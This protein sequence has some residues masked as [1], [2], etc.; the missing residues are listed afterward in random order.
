MDRFLLQDDNLGRL[1]QARATELYERLQKIDVAN[2]GMPAHCLDYFKKSHSQRLFFSIE[3]SAHLLY[4]SIK[5]SGR[6]PEEMIIMDYGAGVGTLYLLAKMTGFKQVVYNDHLDDWR[7][8][9]ELIAVAIGVHIDH[10]I[11]G[12][13]DDCL[14]RLE[15]FRFKCDI[16]TS[17]NVI[18]HIY[19]LDTFYKAI[20][21]K[22][23]QALIYSSTTA[24]KSNPAS[25]LKH[26]LWHRK[27][28]KVFKGKRLVVIERQAHGLSSTK[29]QNL[30][31][32]TRGLAADD[33]KQAID[34]YRKTGKMPDPTIHATNTCDPSNGVWAE[35]LLDQ[36]TYRRLINE[37]LFNV[38]FAPGF[39]DTHYSKSYMNKTGKLLNR[40]IAKGGK[41]SM[42]LAPFM[43][44]IARPR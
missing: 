8:S 20:H 14:R 11:V 19:K 39:W 40:I 3:T 1:I 10:Y 23:P 30:A 28:E 32:A 6:Q 26:M 25:V 42:M 7:M 4:R 18:E 33:L 31:K 41:R 13:I 22:Q 36:H 17:R 38:S 15:Q 44:V 34:E 29:M 21:D 2:L 27:W 24:N 9:A 5:M 35:H 43:Y 12:D 37:N 16:I